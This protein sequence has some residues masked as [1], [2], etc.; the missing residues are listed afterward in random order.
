MGLNTNKTQTN[1]LYCFQGKLIKV[2]NNDEILKAT[3]EKGGKKYLQYD[4]VSGRITDLKV[5]D[6]YEDGSKDLAITITDITEKYTIYF[7]VQ[8]SYFRSFAR[9]VNN[10]DFMENIELFPT[11]KKNGEKSEVSLIAKQNG[12]WI[13]RYYTADH[14]GDMPAAMPIE[15][16]GKLTYDYS[17]Q[18]NFLIAQLLAKFEKSKMPF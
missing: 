5:V 18:N 17:A 12:E 15:I 1:A 6:G 9:S 13:K 16:N 14:M 3:L 10:V 4:S 11:Y 7:G 8:T 2:A